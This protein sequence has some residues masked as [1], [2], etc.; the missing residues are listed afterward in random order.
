MICRK[1]NT[2]GIKFVDADAHQC[3][4]L[5]FPDGPEEA[6]AAKH[7][8]HEV[9]EVL[10]LCRDESYDQWLA[11]CTARPEVMNLWDRLQSYERNGG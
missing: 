5:L 7:V 10:R 3:P 9:L 8:S 6:F 11:L 4:P 2:S 1:C